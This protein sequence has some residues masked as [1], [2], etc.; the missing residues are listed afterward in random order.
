MERPAKM[1]SV[2]TLIYLVNF[3]YSKPSSNTLCWKSNFLCLSQCYVR[4]QKKLNQ[5]W[6]RNHLN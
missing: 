3:I 6:R 2:I 4:S 1:L 5:K